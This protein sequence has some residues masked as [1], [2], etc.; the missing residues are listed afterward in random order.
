MKNFQFTRIQNTVRKE[1][2]RLI[3]RHMNERIE[4]HWTTIRTRKCS[5]SCRPFQR[6]ST[7]MTKERSLKFCFS[8]FLLLLFYFF[9]VETVRWSTEGVGERRFRP[10]SRLTVLREFRKIFE[11]LLINRDDIVVEVQSAN[12][13]R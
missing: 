5:I 4:R 11:L 9:T 6:N 3:D 13:I 1:I 10:G 2:H 8:S 12:R 7:K